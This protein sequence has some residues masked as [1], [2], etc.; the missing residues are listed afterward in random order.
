MTVRYSTVECFNSWGLGV[1]LSHYV[2]WYFLTTDMCSCI[3]YYDIWYNLRC[4]QF[5]AS[6]SHILIALLSNHLLPDTHCSIGRSCASDFVWNCMV[7]KLRRIGSHF[8]VM[9]L[10]SETYC[11]F[12]SICRILHSTEIISWHLWQPV[13]GDGVASGGHPEWDRQ[14]CYG[15]LDHRLAGASIASQIF[16]WSMKYEG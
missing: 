5:F 14:G 4:W 13:A 16:S 3:S 6:R 2:S 9:D 1:R 12:L 7:I 8:L 15:C 10:S 11:R